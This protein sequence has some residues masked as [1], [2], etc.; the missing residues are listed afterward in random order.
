[1]NIL[2]ITQI[3]DTNDPVLGFF[4][5][6]IEEFAKHCEKVTVICLYKGDCALPENVKVLSLGKETRASRFL[7][8]KNFY[9]YLWRER[10]NYDAVFVHMNQIYVILGGLL[11]RLLRKTVGLWYAHGKTS[12]SLRCAS[13]LAHVIFTSTPQ[14]FRVS[15]RKVQIVGQGVDTEY[16]VPGVKSRQKPF[17]VISVGRISPV[18][19]YETLLRAADRLH[20]EPIVVEIV[21]EYATDQQ[22]EYLQKLQAEV[23][24]KK[25][26]HVSFVG[27]LPHADV[28]KSMQN[29]DV[30][31]NM[32]QTG[33]LDK[34]ILEAM[35]C[36]VPVL[37][38]NEA[39]RD[40]GLESKRLN[41]LMFPQGD[42]AALAQKIIEYKRMSGAEREA[43]GRSL[44]DVVVTRHSLSALVPRILAYYE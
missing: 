14:G 13:I 40:I 8:V 11:W 21:G 10:R 9:A 31:V 22:K 36:A 3:V 33:S 37:T 5:R 16:F 44:R 12:F 29:A 30:F 23:K 17:T 4:H 27:G 24:E 34:A 32:S 7:Y 41:A 2:I 42:D 35:A 15:S 39:A 18:K 25:L 26:H 43:L 6:W 1:M 28:V 19:D 38:S 20:N